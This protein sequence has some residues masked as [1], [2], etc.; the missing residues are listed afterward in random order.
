MTR[1]AIAGV[2]AAVTAGVTM[3][4]ELP[5]EAP[6]CASAA[7]HVFQGVACDTLAAPLPITLGFRG[8][9]GHIHRADVEAVFLTILA[10]SIGAPVRAD[11][12]WAFRHRDRS[13]VWADVTVLPDDSVALAMQYWSR[14]PDGTLSRLCA[15]V[16]TIAVAQG[17][18]AVLGA[19]LSERISALG[20]CAA[21]REARLD[22]SAFE[23]PAPSQPHPLTTM[24]L[25]LAIALAV[26]PLIW[27][28]FFRRP[29]P[30]FWRLAA[31]YPD[32]AYDW[33]V[34]H[35]E[36]IV[37]DPDAGKAGRPDE[38]E[39]EGPFLFWVPKLGGRRV[40]VYVRRRGLEESQRAFLRTH[41]LDTREF[42]GG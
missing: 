34:G 25:P 8:R 24:L 30:D 23:P 14:R 22:S 20:R 42:T 32:K 41:G 10:P 21:R 27:W 35:D 31:R 40:A 28:A 4:Q 15:S 16:D 33:F 11:S 26:S 13:H 38:R 5:T 12:T 6:T 1:A 3:A 29:R 2:L 36:W 17:N 9:G 39:F 37:V 7:G 18:P 19:L